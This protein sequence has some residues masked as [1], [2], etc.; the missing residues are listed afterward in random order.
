MA[1]FDPS[2]CVSAAQV[3][4]WIAAYR[5]QRQWPQPSWGTW[6][7]RTETPP[8]VTR[9]WNMG[10][11]STRQRRHWAS[12]PGRQNREFARALE[13]GMELLAM[14]DL[15]DTSTPDVGGCPSKIKEAAYRSY[16]CMYPSDYA[17]FYQGGYRRR[18]CPTCGGL[19][20]DECLLCQTRDYIE[21]QKRTKAARAA[22]KAEQQANKARALKSRC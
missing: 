2:L 21:V 22:L 12:R 1:E 6:I 18:R 8:L 17:L 4:E 13:Q 10:M 9:E 11:A 7:F 3:S 14:G 15:E 20:G 16:H 19:V 5:R